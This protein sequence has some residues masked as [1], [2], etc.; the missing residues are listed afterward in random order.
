VDGGFARCP[1]RPR[2]SQCDAEHEV[3][4]TLGRDAARRFRPVPGQS[5]IGSEV[6][7]DRREYRPD[8]V[9]ESAE[10]VPTV[11]TERRSGL[12]DAHV[13]ATRRV[14]KPWRYP[15]GTQRRGRA[16]ARSRAPG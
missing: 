2:E 9:A 6:G 3:T 14:S 12:Q 5:R 15:P 4:L 11:E 10:A 1:C 13:L 8:F 7:H 16:V